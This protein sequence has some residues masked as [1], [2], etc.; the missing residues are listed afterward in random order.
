M[1]KSDKQSV[2]KECPKTWLNGCLFAL[3]M[4]CVC[5]ACVIGGTVMLYR[6]CDNRK[7]KKPT[8][9]IAQT[10]EIDSVSA[11]KLQDYITRPENIRVF[12]DTMAKSR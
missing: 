5:W 9:K 7:S 10:R 4:S 2:S 1:T 6:S 8:E 12:Q 3:G 11:A